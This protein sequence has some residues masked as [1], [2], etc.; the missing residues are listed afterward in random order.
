MIR[1]IKPIFL[2]AGLTLLGLI[3]TGCGGGDGGDQDPGTA[4]D[5]GLASLTLDS[6]DIDFDRLNTGPYLVTVPADV[7]QVSLTAVKA[8]ENTRLAYTLEST[9]GNS[10]VVTVED[11][12]S[13]TPVTLDIGEG[14]NLITVYVFDDEK[15]ARGE[16]YLR[17]HRIST[18]ASLQDVE[19]GSLVTNTVLN[20]EPD[21]ESD[22]FNYTTSVGYTSCSVIARFFSNERNTTI[23]INDERVRHAQWIP[24]PL[25]VGDNTFETVVT[26]ED[27][28]AT[29]T[30]SFTV[31]RPTPTNSLLVQDANLAGLTLSAG[32]IRFVC[33]N[34]NY[35]V[36]IDR[37]TTSV[38]ITA[39]TAAE[40]A[41]MTINDQTV[42][43]GE[44]FS[45]ALQQGVNE[46]EIE[47]TSADGD[48]TKTYKL[49]LQR[50]DTNIVSVDTA[51]E[52]QAALRNAEPGD[53]I[54]VAGGRYEGIASVDASGNAGAH[55][56]SDRSGTADDMIRL[57]G[58]PTAEAVILA[59]T[60]TSA[61][62]ALLLAGDYW[63]VTGIQFTDAKN[64]IVLSNSSNNQISN[65]AVRGT[66]EHGIIIRDGSS[67]NIVNSALIGETGVNIATDRTGHAEGILVGSDDSE[68]A[69]A[70]GGA[71]LY[72]E[73][74]YDNVIRNSEFLSSVASEAIEVN[75]GTLR[76][77][78][79]H[80]IF[81][82]GS[83]T[84]A[85]GDTSLVNIQGN[86][87]IVRYNT[88]YYEDDE[89]LTEVISVN[90]NAAA[91]N[92]GTSWGESSRIYQ[93]LFAL[94][95]RDVPLV[96][97]Q[98]VTSVLVGD[99]T[100]N[101]E[102][103][104]AYA[105]AGI[106]QD[107]ATPTYKVQPAGDDSVCLD[108]ETVDD[109]LSAQTTVEI[110][111]VRLNECSSDNSQLWKL[112]MDKDKFIRIQ[113]VQFSQMEVDG[114]PQEAYVTPRLGFEYS[115]LGTEGEEVPPLRINPG[116]NGF[117]QRWGTVLN[118]DGIAFINKYQANYAI[119]VPAQF[120]AGGPV[121]ACSTTIA[122]EE[123]QTLRLIEQ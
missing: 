91:W 114:S 103:Q 51:E 102:V 16:Y 31:S 88:F 55:F 18:S 105:G 24:L 26:A 17:V 112:V 34:L 7:S 119:T 99:N 22:V 111:S 122:E 62:A 73:Q 95:G 63:R 118:D 64:G 2:M 35:N 123:Q 82:S 58:D 81:T 38:D 53:E 71:G 92:T 94:E 109:V 56:Y 87:V 33:S 80:N 61:N 89:N 117:M 30:Y 4:P 29:Q 76:T 74:D 12:T 5:V 104:P 116:F 15:V 19:F 52:L 115:C 68:W 85:A 28:V 44:P 25:V 69:G 107:F 78:I 101:D 1:R 97:A 86:D 40:E 32:N 6:Y 54:R 57:A 72:N 84:N 50:L 11:L 41:T 21:F 70:P 65:V 10:G 59:G 23:V 43:S 49:T 100:R 37:D 66:G 96:R 13:G 121:T 42:E 27:G 60:D 39:V 3:L 79:E 14:D 98:D 67:N 9:H 45:V 48:T 83:L 106:N 46:V 8:T 93:N 47:V 120:E 90:D 108:V 110:D 36:L 75:E 113:N 77:I 20:F